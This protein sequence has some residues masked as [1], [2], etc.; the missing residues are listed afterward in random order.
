MWLRWLRNTSGQGTNLGWK[1]EHLTRSIDQVE[2]SLVLVCAWSLYYFYCWL[3]L[4]HKSGV[5]AYF[6]WIRPHRGYALSKGNAHQWFKSWSQ[7]ESIDTSFFRK[8]RNWLGLFWVYCL[9]FSLLMV[10]LLS[11]NHW[12]DDLERK[13]NIWNVSSLS[14]AER[15][16]VIIE[17][18]FVAA[19]ISNNWLSFIAV[20]EYVV[21][22][23][24]RR[25][26]YVFNHPNFNCCCRAPFTNTKPSRA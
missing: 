25:C 14:N 18:K 9:W 23:V 11:W 16:S 1:F 19:S 2:W 15:R 5:W 6:C 3:W 20:S 13:F 8:R 7:V 22:D 17:G 26:L 21:H 12:F 24:L 10:S 4:T